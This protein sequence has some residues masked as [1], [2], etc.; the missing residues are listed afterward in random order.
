MPKIYNLTV[1]HRWR[2]SAPLRCVRNVWERQG[3]DGYV[4]HRQIHPIV[5]RPHRAGET[6]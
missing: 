4:S 5:T 1:K 6:R 2:L 3:R